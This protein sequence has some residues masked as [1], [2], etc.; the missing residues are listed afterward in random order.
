MPIVSRA[1]RTDEYA[2]VD[3]RFG[4]LARAGHISPAGKA[5]AKPVRTR[6]CPATAMPL[7]R[8]RTSQVACSSPTNSALGGRAVRAARAAEPPP[9]AHA[10]VFYGQQQVRRR[11]L[12]LRALSSSRRPGR[13]PR[14]RRR[15]DGRR[16]RIVSLSPTAT[17]DLFAIGAGKQVVAVDDQSNYPASAPQTKLSGYTPNAEAIAAYKPDLVV[18]SFDGNHIV[19]A[20]GKL[21]IPVLVAA[22]RPRNSPRHTRQIRELGG[23]PGT[24]RRRRRVV[25]KMKTQIAAIVEVGAARRSG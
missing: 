12:A 2:Q 19:E 6:R 24:A 25:A 21:K 9:S 11:L 3:A 8:R 1:A 20:L 16:P 17:E 5:A 10:E 7:L 23:Q 14:S 15:G 18:V 4:I 22:D 13:R